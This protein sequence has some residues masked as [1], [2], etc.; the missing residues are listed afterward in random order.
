M[1]FSIRDLLLVTVIVAL[2]LG[3]WVFL[4]RAAP[5]E[6]P[7]STLG[8]LR[9]APSG[10]RAWAKDSPS[11]AAKT[12]RRLNWPAPRGRTRLWAGWKPTPPEVLDT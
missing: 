4:P 1:K 8:Y 2:A 12:R 5:G 10:L 3:W 6:A 9:A 7:G 11:R